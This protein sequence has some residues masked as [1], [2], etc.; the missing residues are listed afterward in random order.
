MLARQAHQWLIP[1]R[2]TVTQVLLDVRSN[3]DEVSASFWSDAQL[4]AF[5]NHA[6]HLV[7]MEVKRIKADYFT[8][9]RTSLDGS[10]TILGE[11]YATSSFALVANTTRY[12]L[13]P[14]VAEVKNLGVHH[15]R[16]RG[17]AVHVPRPDGPAVP[18]VAAMGGC[19]RADGLPR[20]TSRAS[21][22]W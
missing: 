10:V 5:I 1:N 6:Y 9:E 12:T 17:R 14:D 2:R 18:G 3:F 21:G 19:R 13:P 16:L 8:V 11:A 7:W 20:W 4:T 15:Q 22:R